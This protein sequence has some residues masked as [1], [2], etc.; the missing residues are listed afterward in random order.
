MQKLQF[1][2]SYMSDTKWL[3]FFQ[4]LSNEPDLVKKC[5]IKNVGDELLR[6]LA[7]PTKANFEETFYQAGIKD[8]MPS[9][10]MEFKEIELI[11]FPHKWETQRTM[12]DEILSPFRY[13]QATGRIQATIEKLGKFQMELTEEGLTVYGY[14]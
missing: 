14:R 13:A 4:A 3:K 10:P 8:V 6:E 2:G 12:R 7:L 11:K 5:L 1:S 9:G